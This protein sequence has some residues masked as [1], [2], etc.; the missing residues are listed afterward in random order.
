MSDFQNSVGQNFLKNGHPWNYGLTKENNQIMN[1]ISSNGRKLLI[2]TYHSFW[3]DKN[4]ETERF[5]IFE[6]YGY[7][8][9]FFNENDLTRGD[10][11]EYCLGR[12]KNFM[13][14]D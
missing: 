6:K 11:R 1:Q 12:I 8:T 3:H 13:V 9:L 5:K 10:W 7:K 2:E 4:Y 14:V